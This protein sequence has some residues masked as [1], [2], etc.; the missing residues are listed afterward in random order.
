MQM[1]AERNRRKQLL[2]TQA[3]INVAEGQKQ[4]VILESEGHVRLSP[5]LPSFY[6]APA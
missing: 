1:E 5:L 6:S 4:R 2:D 3:Q